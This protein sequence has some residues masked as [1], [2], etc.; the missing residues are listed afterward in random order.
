[1]VNKVL[2]MQFIRYANLFSKVTRI[3]T[4]HCFEYNNAIVFA[5]P[6]K[7]VTRALGEDNQNLRKLNQVIGRKV[8]IV[9]I[10]QGREDIENFVSVITYP[11][12]FKAIEIKDDS[13]T[14]NA[15]N[16]S[17][18]SLIGRN[19]V[20]LNEMTNVLGQYFGIKKVMIK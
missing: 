6:R 13:A 9:A 3:R 17:K 8:K 2:S 4:N 10:P 20:R 19:K 7:L 1:M 5:V 12:R 11:V 14:I 18:A 16:Q 15:S